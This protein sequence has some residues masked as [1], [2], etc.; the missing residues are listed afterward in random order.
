MRNIEI[1]AKDVTL[2]YLLTLIGVICQNE[3]KAQSWCILDYYQVCNVLKN[4]VAVK[5]ELS[6]KM[7]L[8]NHLL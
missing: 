5:Y 6:P 4:Y 2:V 8:W 7:N 1:T 3:N